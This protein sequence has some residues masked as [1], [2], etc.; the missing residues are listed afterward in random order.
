MLESLVKIRSLGLII[1]PIFSTFIGYHS[2]VLN[3]K[4]VHLLIVQDILV[5]PDIL[6]SYFACELSACAGAC[7]W[8]GDFGAPLAEA[9]IPQIELFARQF[10]SILS[11]E[12][13]RTID[14]VGPVTYYS[15]MHA[16]GT[17]L[18]K[19]GSCIFMVLDDKGVASCAIENTWSNGSFELRKPISCHLYPIRHKN[20]ANSPFSLLEYDRWDICSPAC[21]NGRSKGIPLFRF[22]REALTRAF[23]HE[24]Y[25]TLES[26]FSDRVDL[27]D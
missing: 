1:Y 3:L 13:R 23:G 6:R 21:S 4:L 14:A 10:R 7:C 15:G 17:S 11:A 5:S 16:N 12:S 8:E 26:A 24:F 25:E 9:E 19:N 27:G 2:T 18:N 20:P 22:S